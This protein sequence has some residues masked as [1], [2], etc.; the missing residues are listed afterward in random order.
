MVERE[1]GMIQQKETAWERWLAIE[2]SHKL[3]GLFSGI[4]F[5]FA[6]AIYVRPVNSV[7]NFWLG[8]FNIQP[9]W[10]VWVFLLAALLLPLG[11]Y[12]WRNLLVVALATTPLLISMVVLF[13]QLARSETAP[14]FHGAMAIAVIAL[15]NMCFY[16]ARELSV[17]K[18]IALEQLKPSEDEQAK[19]TEKTEIKEGN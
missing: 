5:V 19:P 7:T 1:I 3:I 8:N 9:D 10:V 14:L 16:L 6:T 18:A 15:A 12:L 13:L 17:Y 2:V 4:L 11:W